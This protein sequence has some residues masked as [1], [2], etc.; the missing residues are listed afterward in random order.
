MNHKRARMVKDGE[1]YIYISIYI[2]KNFMGLRA[3]L[4]YIL[5]MQRFRVVYRRISRESAVFSGIHM[6]PVGRWEGWV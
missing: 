6:S 3:K 1:D 4:K 5:V 2:K